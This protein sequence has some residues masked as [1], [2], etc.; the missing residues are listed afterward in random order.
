MAAS[1]SLVRTNGA[2]YKYNSIEGC[3]NELT[4]DTSGSA[5][6]ANDEDD[7][8]DMLSNEQSLLLPDGGSNEYDEEDSDEI[9]ANDQRHME[10]RQQNRFFVL[11]L[12]ALTPTGVKSVSYTHLRAHET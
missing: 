9:R 5:A 10:Y 6:S 3:T 7:Y 11:A 8:R 4:D 12:V 2:T 1:Q